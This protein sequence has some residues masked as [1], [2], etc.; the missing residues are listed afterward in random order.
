MADKKALAGLKEAKR[1]LN[2]L[3]RKVRERKAGAGST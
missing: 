1:K 3:Y 2:E